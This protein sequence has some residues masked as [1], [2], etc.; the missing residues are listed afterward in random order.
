MTEGQLLVIVQAAGYRAFQRGDEIAVETCVF[1]GNS[2]A[3]LELSASKGVYH[4][5]VCGKGGRLGNL[6]KTLTGSDEY[7]GTAVRLDGTSGTPRQQVV[8]NLRTIPVEQAEVAAAFLTRRGVSG[9]VAKHY[10]IGV[11]VD[12]AHA[13][14]G[15]IV[16]PAR[17]FWT[18]EC[19][20]WWGRTY[21]H[22]QP[23]YLASFTTKVIA[24]WPAYESR[25]D[26]P[27]VMVEG[28]FDGIA[29]NQAGY[30]VAVL[31]GI[32]GGDALLWWAT[33]LA[34][35]RTIVIMLDSDAEDRARSLYWKLRQVRSD[36]RI[37][38]LPP[39]T[40]PGSATTNQLRGAIA[41]SDGAVT[42]S[43]IP[44]L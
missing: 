39:G 29:T 11:C 34:P 3:N 20:G 44:I 23:K 1:C 5:W 16:I 2:K 31:S 12:E 40:D 33:R 6:L 10:G 22:K 7:S 35:E 19:V 37:A 32:T 15:R 26:R 30:D 28:P 13:L 42:S 8:P 14:Y 41:T 21:T 18:G 43:S 9:L 38:A 24:G 17:D 36:I 25:K 27:L 4:C